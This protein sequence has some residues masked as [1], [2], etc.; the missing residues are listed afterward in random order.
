LILSISSI[1][2]GGV[3][4]EKFEELKQIGFGGAALLGSLWE[5]K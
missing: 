3:R 5:E 4:E 1:A 2:L